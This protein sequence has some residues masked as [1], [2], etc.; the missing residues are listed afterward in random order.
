MEKAL[1][2]CLTLHEILFP[3]IHNRVRLLD[4]VI[5][6]SPDLD[7]HREDLAQLSEY[8]VQVRYPDD[9]IEPERDETYRA[10][11]LAEE[12]VERIKR[13]LPQNT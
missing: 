4:L 3:R 13:Q 2:A 6:A 10:L 7:V 12:I 1:K 5:A 8:A 11:S 9:F